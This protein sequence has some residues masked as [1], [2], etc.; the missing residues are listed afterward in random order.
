MDLSLHHEPLTD[1]F[2]ESQPELAAVDGNEFEHSGFVTGVPLLS[3]NQI[4]ALRDALDILMAENADDPLF[5]EYHTNE[6]KDESGRLLHALGAW[7][8]SPAFHD[9]IFFRPIV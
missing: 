8:I 2:A 6:S 9:L 7:R 3:E 1:L 5:Y 4:I